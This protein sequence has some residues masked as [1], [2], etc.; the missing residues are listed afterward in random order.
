VSDEAMRAMV[1]NVPVPEFDSTPFTLPPPLR[2]ATVAI[3]TTAALRRRED[4]PWARG[5]ESFRVLADTTRNV[6]VGHASP[7]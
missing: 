3:V 2:E 7:N 4:P 5:D 1:N 6:T